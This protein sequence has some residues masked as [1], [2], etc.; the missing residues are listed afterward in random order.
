MRLSQSCA[1][2]TMLKIALC[3]IVK[4][5]SEVED[6]KEMLVS[7]IDYVDGVYIVA[8]G[9]KTADIEDLVRFA[10]SK[11]PQKDIKY[12]Y[13]KWNGDFS[14]QRNYNFSLVPKNT[15]YILWLD[16]DDLLVGGEKL[17][18]LAEQVKKTK[19]DV[20]FLEYWYGCRFKGKPSLDTLEEVEIK[21]YRER[22]IK[23]NSI[24]WKKRVHETPV[25]VTGQKDSYTKV[26]YDPKVNP[27]AVLHKASM[28]DAMEKLDRNR[29]LLEA[30]LKDEREMGAADPR[31]ILYLM[32][33]YAES[34]DEEILRKCIEMG[35]EYLG[36]S[37]WDEERATACDLMS[38]CYTKL[39][40]FAESV[41]FLHAA[42][43]EFPYEPLHY[44]RLALAYFNLGKYR[45]SKHWLNIAAQMDLDDHTAGI[46]NIK[47]MKILFAQTL[48]KLKF[49]AEKDIK[50]A[51][52]AAKLLYKE[53]PIEAN[54]ENLEY[55][56]DL[57]DL[58]NAS[59][60][61]K[62]LFDYLD[63]I[64]D[65]N[66]LDTL[67]SLP[68]AISE[69]PWAISVRRRVTPPRVW[70]ENE[71]CYFANFGG[72]HFEKWDGKSLSK[73]IGGSETAVIE[74][75]REWTNQGYKVTV[76]GDPQYMGEHD[77]VM[78][79]PWYYFNPG[80]KFNIFI[81]WRNATLAPRV[82]SKKFI[83]DLHDVVAQ[84]DYSDE[85]MNAIDLV[86]F[87][88]KYHRDMLPDLP[89]SKAIILSNGVI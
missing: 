66:I 11:Y 53:Q 80:D 64:D 68:I 78:Y 28:D 3:S 24:I 67:N 83:V 81:Q 54:K 46:K 65:P 37:G 51:F 30:E 18:D 44:I 45:E 75:S 8:N 31:T 77:G 89:D 35:H 50:G 2:Q 55:I 70:K 56:N 5:D 43:E 73:G 61:T 25:P 39:G 74:L 88:S 26:P 1:A 4:D 16:A 87:K 76:Y 52:E 33:I 41:K 10:S 40:L 14:E 7:A 69:Q 47:E 32:K 49:N 82:K 13:L 85:I 19:N 21:H 12:R 23:P 15:D 62:K 59:E 36:L 63:S 6:L 72:K 20:I 17:R 57:Y 84:V 27:I 79:L 29:T 34:G 48:L 38:I 9:E 71:I 60:D 42:I 58:Y 86:M 22:L